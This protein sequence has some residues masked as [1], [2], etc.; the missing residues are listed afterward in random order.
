M[1]R[2]RWH[3]GLG[4]HDRER[5][6]YMRLAGHTLSFSGTA[7]VCPSKSG[8]RRTWMPRRRSALRTRNAA[9]RLRCSGGLHLEWLL[10]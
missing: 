1:S 2:Y 10:R 9:N 3:Q 5:A 8:P 4:T 7:E 6:D